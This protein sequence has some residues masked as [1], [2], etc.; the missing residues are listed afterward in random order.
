MLLCDWQSFIKQS[1]YYYYYYYYCNLAQIKT[2]TC[3][4]AI[5]V[6]V[7]SLTLTHYQPTDLGYSFVT[8]FR[9]RLIHESQIFSSFL[10]VRTGFDIYAGHLIRE[11]VF[12][13]QRRQRWRRLLPLLLPPLLLI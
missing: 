3:T 4:L 2:V 13:R 12:S 9:Y 6:V 5:V 10:I 7:N 11:Y 1:Y 8:D